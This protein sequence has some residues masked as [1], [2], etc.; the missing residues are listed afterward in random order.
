MAVVKRRM[1]PEREKVRKPA[2]PAENEEL[3]LPTE[4]TKRMTR[5]GDF[6][7][8]LYGERKI[9]KTT[10]ASLFPDAFFL[11]TE[12][13]GK[14]LELMSRPVTNW[15]T[16]TGYIKLLEKDKQ[17]NTIVVDT[18]D[19]AFKMASESA[20]RKLGIDH[21]SE[22]DW[23]KGWAAI[24]DTFNPWMQRLLSL[25][26][27]VILISHSETKT[28]KRRGGGDYDRI[29]PTL[30]KQGRKFVD[31]A[32]DMWFY[33]AYD[34]KDRYLTIKGDDYINAGHRLQT[35]HF[36]INGQE[37]ER[38]SMGRTP[39]EGYKNLI[40]AFSNQ[41]RPASE[42]PEAGTKKLTLKKKV[43]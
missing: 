30:S 25:N 7:L 43:S 23:G 16:F 15:K 24:E 3:T 32:V 17:F 4:L 11:F 22:E 31:G 29:Q 10:L 33:Y 27:G 38:V 40:D 12:P 9:G 5:F 2:P 37:L 36:R 1:P 19:L 14:D 26:K 39:A 41:Y 13:G 18:V 35:D 28:I 34:G 42:I 8:W 21:P 20:M 6:S